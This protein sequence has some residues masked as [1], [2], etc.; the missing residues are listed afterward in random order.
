MHESVNRRAADGDESTVDA[1]VWF[2]EMRDPAA[3]R[4]GRPPDVAP[5]LLRAERPA[6]A[7]AA[8]F[9]RLVGTRWHWVDRLPWT[10]DDWRAWVDRPEEVL[11][12]CWVDGAPAGYFDLEVQGPAGSVVE[13]VYFGLVD[14]VHGLGLGGWLLTEAVRTAWSIPG[15]ERV[16][17]QTCSLDGPVALANYTA[18]G[19][20]VF[21]ERVEQRHI[22]SG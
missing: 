14:D 1:T 10:E 12:T 4:P 20:T 22:R 3:L 15:V 5:V 6:P 2:L 8:F 21:D 17:L 11:A 9:Y 16:W 18:R 19:F 7:L 13:L